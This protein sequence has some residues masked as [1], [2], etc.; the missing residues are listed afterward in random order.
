MSRGSSGSGG[1][2]E[3]SNVRKPI[4]FGKYAYRLWITLCIM[5]GIWI[6]SLMIIWL[7]SVSIGV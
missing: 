6:I 5:S 7:V 2:G 4:V 3:I 1:A